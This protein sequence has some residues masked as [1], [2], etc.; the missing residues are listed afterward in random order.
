MALLTA[1]A[2]KA[3]QTIDH[4]PPSHGAFCYLINIQIVTTSGQTTLTYNSFTSQLKPLVTLVTLPRHRYCR[5]YPTTLITDLVFAPNTSSE[6]Y[7]GARFTRKD[8][9][10]T[11]KSEGPFS[12]WAS[13]ISNN[14]YF[15]A[16]HKHESVIELR[17]GHSILTIFR[18]LGFVGD[19]VYKIILLTDFHLQLK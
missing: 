19:G 9:L 5:S 2:I 4:A 18:C 14:Y 13:L 1:P 15:I 3:G 11:L 6:L 16:F 10:T 17:I 7:A 12:L 8:S